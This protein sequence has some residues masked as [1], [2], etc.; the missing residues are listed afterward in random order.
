MTD[1]KQ[2]EAT[3]AAVENTETEA[4]TT[5]TES[6]TQ[7][8]LDRIIEDRLAK[9]RRA[10]E[11]RYAGVDPEKY[12]KIMEDQEAKRLEDAKSKAEFEN[13]LRDTVGKKDSLIANLRSELHSVKVDGAVIGAANKAGAIN[14]QQVA[15]LIKN[16]IRLGDDGG[17]EV[18]DPNGQLRYTDKGEPMSVE[19]LVNEF[20]HANPH[21][22]TATPGGTNS[23]SNLAPNNAVESFDLSTLDMTN[24]AHRKLYKQA[25]AQGKL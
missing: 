8:Q 7:E 2:D 23:K 17:V 10:L 9:Q 11:K 16:Q 25:K 5:N 20:I 4:N 21:F 13:I 22:K 12:H 24:P 6:F 14:A 3:Q 18:T 1:I 15:S 19:A